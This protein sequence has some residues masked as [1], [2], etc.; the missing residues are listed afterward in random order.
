MASK[1]GGGKPKGK[2]PAKKV[3]QKRPAIDLSDSEDDDGVEDQRVILQQLAAL[4]EVQGL[5]PGWP[6][7][8]GK[9]AKGHVTRQMAQNQFQ[10]QV[11]YRL[12]CLAQSKGAAEPIWREDQLEQQQDNAEVRIAGSS[13]GRMVVV[14]AT[15]VARGG[16]SPAAPTQG[17]QGSDHCLQG[18]GSHPSHTL[19]SGDGGNVATSSGE[20]AALLQPAILA[21]VIGALLPRVTLLAKALGGLQQTEDQ[22]VQT[23]GKEV[24][25]GGSQPVDKP[26]FPGVFAVGASLRKQFLGLVRIHP[27]HLGI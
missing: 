27:D 18:L 23:G 5:S 10:A 9:G 7:C 15:T 13:A 3:P 8:I 26:I 24:S 25:A 20:L 1:K 21:Q 4:E 17:V 14:P 16:E 19:G 12:M 2:Q 22:S 6:V 11:H